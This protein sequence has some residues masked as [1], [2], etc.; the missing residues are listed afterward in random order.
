MD[1]NMDQPVVS[2]IRHPELFFPDGSVVISAQ[3]TLFKVY[4]GVLALN[5]EVFRDMFSIAS[6]TLPADAP[7]YDGCP[8]IQ[9]PDE[10][11]DLERFLKALF[12]NGCV[13]VPGSF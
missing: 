4:I 2:Q 7:T 10:A 9:M 6:G 12:I 13:R 11:I 3:Q 5:S 8:L 1:T